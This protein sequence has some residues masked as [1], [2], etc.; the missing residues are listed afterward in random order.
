[1]SGLGTTAID[2]RGDV[3]VVALAGAIDAYNVWEVEAA[4]DQIDP[5]ERQ[6]WSTSRA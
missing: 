1:V 6:V 3:T 4:F 5:A 2:E